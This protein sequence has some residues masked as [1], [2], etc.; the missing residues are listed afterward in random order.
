M[1]ISGQLLPCTSRSFIKSKRKVTATDNMYVVE[2]N[3][4][5]LRDKY[6]F[7]F[8]EI[9]NIDKDDP[10]YNFY[11]NRI[12]VKFNDRLIKLS[13]FSDK[14][15]VE[16][17]KSYKI[18]KDTE[19]I[20]GCWVNGFYIDIESKSINNQHKNSIYFLEKD[21]SSINCWS[22]KI[23]AYKTS[24]S[25]NNARILMPGVCCGLNDKTSII[26]KVSPK[27]KLKIFFRIKEVVSVKIK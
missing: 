27:T 21:R 10:L 14:R 9:K 20:N 6:A 16:N 2:I 12:P 24:I 19:S 23:A 22:T 13:S 17:D 5:S 4:K 7:V 18:H 25:K 8:N 15:F 11:K 26:F 3:N 1:D